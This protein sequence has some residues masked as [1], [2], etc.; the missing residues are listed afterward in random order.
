MIDEAGVSNLCDLGLDDAPEGIS[1]WEGGIKTVHF[2]S[3]DC[4]EYDSSLIGSFRAPTP[5]EWESIMKA[6][7]PWCEDDWNP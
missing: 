5:A 3:P 7:C 6:E 1:I 2:H 4:N